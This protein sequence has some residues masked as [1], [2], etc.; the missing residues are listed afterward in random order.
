MEYGSI[1]RTTEGKL[2]FLIEPTIHDFIMKSERK[3]QIL[4]PKD[5]GYIAART[6]IKNGSKIL[7]IGTGSGAAATYMAG[8]VKPEGHVYRFAVNPEFMQI[9]A[10]NLEKSG[11]ASFVM[12]NEHDPHLGVDLR[13]AD[14]ALVDLGDPW[15]VLD[16]VHE[17]LKGSGGFAAICP[18][19]NQAEKTATEL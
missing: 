7:E 15:T 18:T 13:D 2:I 16:Q 3:T 5:L 17:A 19:M 1:T 12:L 14:M 9:A 8:I 11:M 4:Y 6:G 10:R